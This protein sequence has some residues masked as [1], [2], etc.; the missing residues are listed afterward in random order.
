MRAVNLNYNFEKILKI[1]KTHLVLWKKCVDCEALVTTSLQNNTS[2]NM[3][4]DMEL[5]NFFNDLNYIKN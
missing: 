5:F 2:G 4:Q 1:I 3:S